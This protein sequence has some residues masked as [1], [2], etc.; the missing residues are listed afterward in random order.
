MCSKS[1]R[2]KIQPDSSILQDEQYKPT[3]AEK[4]IVQEIAD[5]EKTKTPSLRIKIEKLENNTCQVGPDHPDQAIGLALLKKI[6]GTN[7]IEF[8]EHLFS[9]LVELDQNSLEERS[10]RQVRHPGE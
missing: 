7:S 9:H 2:K 1:N 5:R 3:L 4:A 8:A 10:C 6:F